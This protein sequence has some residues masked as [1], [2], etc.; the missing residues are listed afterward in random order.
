MTTTTR[1]VPSLG[2]HQYAIRWPKDRQAID[3]VQQSGESQ[4]T[5][6]ATMAG[7]A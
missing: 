5:Q 3:R 1:Y 2:E 6:L 7:Y 4:V